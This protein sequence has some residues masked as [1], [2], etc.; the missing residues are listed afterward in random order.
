M[1]KSLLTAILILSGLSMYAADITV[2]SNAFTSGSATSLAASMDAEIDFALQGKAQKMTAAEA[3]T[4]LSGFFGAN[5]PA[6]FTVAHNA[7]KKES[8]FLVGKLA[9]DKGEFRVN[10]TYIVKDNKIIIQSIRIE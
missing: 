9:T 8:G 3:V 4:Q 7:D 2:I 1:K 6:G 10:I 5:K